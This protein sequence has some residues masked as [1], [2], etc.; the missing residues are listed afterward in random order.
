MHLCNFGGSRSSLTTLCVVT[1]RYV[2]VITRVQL[3]WG[4]TAHLK[5]RRPKMSKIRRDLGHLSTLTANISGRH[6][7]IDKR[8]TALSRAIHPALNT[9][10]LLT[11]VY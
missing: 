1:C 10:K 5:F 2:W 8:S 9:K 7:D 4:G 11:L 6:K 3:F